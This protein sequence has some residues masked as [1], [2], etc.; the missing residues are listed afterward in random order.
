M[1]TKFENRCVL[2]T[3]HSTETYLRYN[4][5]RKKINQN[6]H[7]RSTSKIVLIP[8]KYDFFRYVQE[9]EIKGDILGWN[10]S[11]DKNEEYTYEIFYYL[12]SCSH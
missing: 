3:Y 2:N 8:T 5:Q 4:V 7:V 10:T 11:T 1:I 9:N 12:V 6:I